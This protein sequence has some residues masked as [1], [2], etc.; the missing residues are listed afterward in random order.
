VSYATE[1]QL[2]ERF[3]EPMLVDLTDRAD[4]PA[5]EVDSDVVARALADTDA[6]IDGYLAARY[7]LPLA[8]TPAMLTDL[9][10]S[11]AIY[12]C[13]RNVASEKVQRDYDNALKMLRD[14][15]AGTIRLPL[16]AGAEPAAAGGSGVRVS[17]PDRPMTAGTM[18]GYI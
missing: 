5:G 14:I 2:I 8:E 12:K 7:A 9:A 6:M 1:A 11:I 3:G 16:A 18:K 15:A 13:H 4:P 17:Q 10:L